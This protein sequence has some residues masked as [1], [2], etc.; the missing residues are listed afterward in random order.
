MSGW[1]YFV[2]LAG[3][4]TGSNLFEQTVNLCDDISCLGELYNPAFVGRPKFDAENFPEMKDRDNDPVAYLE[5]TISENSGNLVGFRLFDGHDHRILDHVLADE[6]CA[7]IVLRRNPLDAYLSRQIARQTDQWRVSDWSKRRTALVEFDPASFEKYLMDQDLYYRGIDHILKAVGQAPL[8]LNYEDLL[9]QEIWPGVFKF[10]GIK[11]Y[12]PRMQ[13]RLIRQNP[14]SAEEK[15]TNPQALEPYLMRFDGWAGTAPISTDAS[16]MPRIAIDLLNGTAMD[17]SNGYF[18]RRGKAAVFVKSAQVETVE[19]PAMLENW[20]AKFPDHSLVFPVEHPLHRAYRCFDRYVLGG[21]SRP[22]RKIRQ[23]IEQ[24]Y[25]FA[26]FE[27]ASQGNLESYQTGFGVFLEYLEPHL[28]G[29]TKV[30]PDPV[31]AYQH[32]NLSKAQNFVSKTSLHFQR[33]DGN[34]GL[35]IHKGILPIDQVTNDATMA[36]SFNAYRPDVLRFG[37][38]E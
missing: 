15:V 38:T 28:A 1:S 2:L 4:R 21:A 26:D 17:G 3:M 8:N 11:D 7:K 14:E 16:Q 34:D 25:G 30:I 19:G 24:F 31:W 12:T 9:D 22:G 35:P 6:K 36:A 20:M 27:A 29:R 23:N 10:L 33:L 18:F 37:I 13:G 32:P 5:K